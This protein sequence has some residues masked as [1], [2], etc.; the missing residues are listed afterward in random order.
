MNK[1]I[2]IL[3]ITISIIIGAILSGVVLKQ[4]TNTDT[5]IGNANI[6]GHEFHLEIARTLDE[7]KKGLSG[8]NSICDNCGMLFIFEKPEEYSFWMKD[9]KFS[10]DIIW[11]MNEKIVY[12]AQNIPYNYK[13]SISPDVLADKVLE[14]NGGI[15]K[16][17]S[18][19]IGDELDF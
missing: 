18:L 7:R 3:F 14:I 6:K 19:R 5:D 1:K 2:I 12:I 15:S 13:E 11:I 16:K 4:N 9:M 10:I 17:L 8:K